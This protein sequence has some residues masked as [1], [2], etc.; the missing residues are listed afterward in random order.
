[1]TKY[2]K[3]Y[4]LQDVTNMILE[5]AHAKFEAG[6]LSKN[7]DDFIKWMKES[8]NIYNTLYKE[9]EKLVLED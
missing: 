1:M 4:K 2:E 3:I 9:L 8:D 7:H 5:F 6:F